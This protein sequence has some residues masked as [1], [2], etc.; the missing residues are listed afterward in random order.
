MPRATL[1]LLFL[2]AANPLAQTPKQKSPR[3]NYVG[4]ATCAACHQPLSDHYSITNHHLTSQLPT[5]KSISGSFTPPD[6]TLATRDPDLRFRMEAR[7]NGFY[8]SAIFWHPP[9]EQTRSEKI[10]FVTG[11]GKKGQTYLTWRNNQLFQLPISYWIDFGW[12]NSPGYTDGTADFN[13]PI[14]P[15][16]LEC[17]ATYFEN[18][19]SPAAPNFYRKTNFTLGISCERCHGPGRQHVEAEHAHAGSPANA[20]AAARSTSS[21]QSVTTHAI[22]NPAKLTRD[23]QIEVCSQCHAGIGEDIAPAFSYTP[24]QPLN[25][26]IAL[27]KPDPTARVDVHGNQV[28]LLQRSLCYQKSQMTCTTC[29]DVHNAEQPATTYSEKCLQ[30]HKP[31]DCG[32]F[33]KLGPKISDNC[34]DC[35]MPV[36]P[37]QSITS[38]TTK[39]PASAQIRTHQIKPYPAQ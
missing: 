25:K 35:H 36:Q 7:P 4:D 17:H 16:C 3:T 24:G 13:R 32:E 37:S 29:H 11:S 2:L 8:Q 34:I 38:A 15:R 30:C 31:Q 9:D 1:L 39:S 18:I 23:Q 10:D 26:F 19:P 28:A 12:I 6:N 20:N 22:I 5:A 21:A 27:Q 33:Q 14:V